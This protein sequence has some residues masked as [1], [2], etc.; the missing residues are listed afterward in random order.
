MKSLWDVF[1]LEATHRC[2]QTPLLTTQSGHE[3]AVCSVVFASIDTLL[4]TSWD[5]CEPFFVYSPQYETV[6]P[7]HGNVHMFSKPGANACCLR[8]FVL[9]T[10]LH[11]SQHSARVD[12][13][14][15]L[16]DSQGP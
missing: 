11:H 5:G 9:S 15:M 10:H 4:T 12:S 1:F 14:H 16:R 13:G 3:N 6:S 2:P 7:L 8:H